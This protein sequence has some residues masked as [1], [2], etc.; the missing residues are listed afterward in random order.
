[1]TIGRL[2]LVWLA[3][4]AWAANAGYA[5]PPHAPVKGVAKPVSMKAV[6]PMSV[7]AGAPTAV[8]TVGLMGARRGSVGGPVNKG[9]SING[10]AAP[11]PHWAGEHAVP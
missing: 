4:G 2:L 5:E 7:K 8:R 9:P 1:M 10:T 11:R 3:L 6:W